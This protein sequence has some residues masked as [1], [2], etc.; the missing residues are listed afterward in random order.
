MGVVLSGHGILRLPPDP[1]HAKPTETTA[2]DRR[3]LRPRTAR[4]LG[5]IIESLA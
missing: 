4:S 5:V 1:M 2:I 3:M